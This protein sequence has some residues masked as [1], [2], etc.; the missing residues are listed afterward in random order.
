MGYYLDVLPRHRRRAGPGPAR[1]GRAARGRG[2]PD[3]HPNDPA[4][5]TM[6]IWDVWNQRRL[7]GLPR[8]RAAVRRRVR[9]AGPADV[10]DPAPLAVRRPADARLARHA[11][12]TRRRWTA[13]ASSPAAWSLTCRCPTTST[14]GTG[15]CRS[16][17]PARSQLG[18][19]HFR[20]LSPLC[21]GQRRVA[22]Q[23]L[24]AGDVVGGRRRRRPAQAAVLRACG[25]PTP[26]GWSPCSRAT[27]ASSPYWSTTRPRRGPS[28]CRSP[29][30]T[31]TARSCTAPSRS[32][33]SPPGRP[34]CCRWRPRS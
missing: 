7:P 9:L 1:T 28:S 3:H 25:T 19:E 4:H 23:R 13:T 18:V 20:S 22:A 32:S 24:L 2:R 21:I 34:P 15:R 10:G 26:T 6:H 16:T 27:A 5:G 33:R 8:L 30:V 14:T 12:T 17:R 31:T 11:G 29:V